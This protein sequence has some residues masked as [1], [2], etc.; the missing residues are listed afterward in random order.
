MHVPELRLID[1]AVEGILDTEIRELCE[2]LRDLRSGRFAD[3]QSGTLL[4]FLH[5]FFLPDDQKRFVQIG[6]ATLCSEFWLLRKVSECHQ[7]SVFR[8]C[9]E[10]ILISG[11]HVD[12]ASGQRIYSVLNSSMRPLC[13]DLK[14]KKMGR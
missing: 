10:L 2:E 11:I 4:S 1:M 5:C 8:L 6:R 3:I 14:R 9:R 12:S 13:K 7:S